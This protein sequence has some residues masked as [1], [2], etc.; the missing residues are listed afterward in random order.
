[1]FHNVII[2]KPLVTPDHLFA[3]SFE[4]WD[5]NEFSDTLFTEERFLPKVMVE[6]GIAPTVSEVRRNQPILCRTLN[7]V[8]FEEVKWGKNKIYICIGE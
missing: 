3:Y 7:K 2:G 1:M 6:A 5:K 8:D 4:D